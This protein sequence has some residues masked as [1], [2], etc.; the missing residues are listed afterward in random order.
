LCSTVYLSL[1]KAA[2]ESPVIHS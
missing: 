1:C 2:E